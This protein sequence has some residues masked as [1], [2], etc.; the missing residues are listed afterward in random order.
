MHAQ[1]ID[2]NDRLAALKQEADRRG[3]APPPSPK[4][5]NWTRAFFELYCDLPLAER[6][7]RSLAY[8]LELEPVCIHP[9]SRLAGQI[10]QACPGSGSLDLYGGQDPRW[11]EYAAVPVAARIVH[12][13]LP[14][15]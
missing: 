8:A 3:A 13:A 12:K 5:A 9:H 4:E 15:N 6:Q 14:E 2:V 11:D 7:A 1:G 10:Y